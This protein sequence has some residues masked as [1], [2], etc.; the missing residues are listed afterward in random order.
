MKL[1]QKLETSVLPL[2]LLFL[3]LAFA[4]QD[5]DYEAYATLPGPPRRYPS[6]TSQGITLLSVTTRTIITT[7]QP[8]T[9][10]TVTAPT[11]QPQLPVSNDFITLQVAPSTLLTEISLPPL[12]LDG[13]QNDNQTLIYIPAGSTAACQ[14]DLGLG[15][16]ICPAVLTLILAM[17]VVML[18]GGNMK[19]LL[20]IM[21]VLM[22]RLIASFCSVDAKMDAATPVLS[23]ADACSIVPTTTLDA[24]PGGLKAIWPPARKGMVLPQPQVDPITI[25]GVV[26]PTVYIPGFDLSTDGV[27]IDI[28]AAIVYPTGIQADG[29]TFP[30]SAANRTINSPSKF[31]WSM[32]IGWHAAAYALGIGRVMS[33]KGF[34]IVVLLVGVL[35]SPASFIPRANASTVS[36]TTQASTEIAVPGITPP[37]GLDL[38]ALRLSVE[39]QWENP[40]VF[41]T[42]PDWNFNPPD[43]DAPPPIPSNA[44]VY[45]NGN[46][47]IVPF[48]G[49]NRSYQFSFGIWGLLGLIGAAGALANSHTFRRGTAVALILCLILGMMGVVSASPSP[50]TGPQ[51]DLSDFDIGEY[52]SPEGRMRY[53]SYGGQMV[54]IGLVQTTATYVPDDLLYSMPPVPTVKWLT[55]LSELQA[56][57]RPTRTSTVVQT[58]METVVV[59]A[60]MERVT[61]TRTYGTS[62]LITTTTRPASMTPSYTTFTS[63]E[64]TSTATTLET[65]A[66]MPTTTQ[67]AFP[68]PDDNR[69]ET[70][71]ARKLTVLGARYGVSVFFVVVGLGCYVYAFTWA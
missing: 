63:T 25:P 30:E 71:D 55:P 41:K 4:T 10:L 60:S 59:P 47:P 23:S 15:L 53:I 35:S 56:M 7:A 2:L 22:M 11:N 26:I 46:Y 36:I 42:G 61:V 27:G 19:L 16:N 38:A 1:S 21:L 44:I 50:N 69:N 54:D 68:L 39:N 18:A 49:S 45:P 12:I 65:A 64:G 17:Q 62:T 51:F 37:P 20:L 31:I 57:T 33:R 14:Y 40:V 34:L 8:I 3:T 5:P 6:P 70:S 52:N 24:G 32:V 43:P 58:V 13:A 9:T 28:D 29:R 67:W 66:A 48:S